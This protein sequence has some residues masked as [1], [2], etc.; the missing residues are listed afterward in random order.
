MDGVQLTQ[1]IS[2]LYPHL[3]VI[4]LSSI[5]ETVCRQY[6]HLFAAI[7]N[8]P[9][10]QQVLCGYMIEAMRSHL[11]K[12]AEFGNRKK[13]ELSVHFAAKHP[14]R[15]LVAEDE[16]VNQKLA[17]H[18]FTKLGYEIGIAKNGKVAI[19][20]ASEQPYDIVFMD[21]QMPEMDGLTAGEYIATNFEVKPIIIAMTANVMQGDRDRCLAAGMDDYIAKPIN[22]K[23]LLDKLDKWSVHI[24]KSAAESVSVS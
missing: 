6:S 12:P 15:I 8:K 23:D 21:I 20:M 18:I 13:S 24:T 14:L 17:K 1:K 9:V 11:K 2:V 16:P 3:P 4:V 7:V 19:Q 22:F 10:K 5:G